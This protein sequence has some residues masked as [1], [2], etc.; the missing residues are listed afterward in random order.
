MDGLVD[1]SIAH[2]ETVQ[3][4]FLIETRCLTFG[5]AGSYHHFIPLCFHEHVVVGQGVWTTDHGSS[6]IS[7]LP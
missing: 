4:G 5:M 6:R 1:G 7:A 3:A 2:S